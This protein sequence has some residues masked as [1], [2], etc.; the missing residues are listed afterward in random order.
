MCFLLMFFFRHHGHTHGCLVSGFLAVGAGESGSATLTPS[1]FANMDAALNIL[2]P[3]AHWLKAVHGGI[4][5]QAMCPHSV[6]CLSGQAPGLMICWTG[7][8]SECSMGQS[9]AFLGF[10]HM[11][12]RFRGKGWSVLICCPSMKLRCTPRRDS[13]EALLLL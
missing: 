1:L 11:E 8:C 13:W 2:M 6:W 7:N 12:T 3:P 4:A 9:W 5:Y 10:L